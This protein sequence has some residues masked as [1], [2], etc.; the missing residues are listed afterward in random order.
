MMSSRAEIDLVRRDRRSS[1]LRLGSV[2]YLNAR[3]LIYGLHESEDLHLSLEVPSRLL[4]GMRHGRFDV[5]LLPVIDYQRMP[6]LRVLP[7]AGGIG[8][9]GP[10]LTVRIFSPRP[11]ER[12]ETLACD[13]DS[14]TSVALARIVLAEQYGLRPEFVDLKA[15]D[16][17]LHRDGRAMLLIGDKVVC[18]EPAGLEHQL[19]LGAAW[20][21][22]TGLP[23]VFA[24]W[25][26]RD[27]V[28][29]GELPARLEQARQ[30]GLANVSD[31]ITRHAVPRGWPAGVA[32]QYLTLYLH[33]EIGPRQLEAI[34]LFHRKA[35]EHGII[36]SPP[37]ELEILGA[38]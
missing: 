5:A 36:P 15:D 26:V 19:D 9:D 29:L 31:I 30:A 7:A 3:P 13:T 24:A 37:R 25:M 6:G 14:H 27:G 21:Q 1:A 34:R 17:R 2:S 33:Y 10:T 12:I 23:F 22:M 16:G 38:G 20:K 8:C 32:L 28:E 11:I 18:E 35:A 4:D